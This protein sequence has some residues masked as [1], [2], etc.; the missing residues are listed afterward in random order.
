MMTVRLKEIA[1][2]PRNPSFAGGTRSG[3][4]PFPP[5]TRNEIIAAGAVDY[6]ACLAK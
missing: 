1:F 2:Y 3:P 6:P 5:F 4:P